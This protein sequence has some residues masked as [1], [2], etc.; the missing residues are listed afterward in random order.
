M[1][2]NEGQFPSGC[3]HVWLWHFDMHSEPLFWNNWFAKVSKP[4]EKQ[5][6]KSGHHYYSLLWF[7]AE[8]DLSAAWGAWQRTQ[9]LVS[10]SV[11]MGY[12]SFIGSLNAASL[13]CNGNNCSIWWLILKSLKAQP[14]NPLIQVIVNNLFNFWEM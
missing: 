9:H 4:Y 10:Y 8:N 6:F 2:F 5:C 14:F 12:A 11:G 13:W 7:P 1:T 3:H